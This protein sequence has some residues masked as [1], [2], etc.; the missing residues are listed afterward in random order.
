MTGLGPVGLLV[1]VS[2]GVGAILVLAVGV[3]GAIHLAGILEDRSDRRRKALAGAVCSCGHPHGM[4]GQEHGPCH[5][6]EIVPVRQAEPL[7]DGKG[8]PVFDVDDVLVEVERVVEVRDRRC[9]CQHYDGPEPWPE[10]FA[11]PL[12]PPRS[13]T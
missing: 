6:D 10:V 11:A 3:I 4:H 1:D 5:R 2:I 9:P 12:L 13:G 8:D 7:R